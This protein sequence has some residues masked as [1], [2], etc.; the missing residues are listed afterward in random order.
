MKIMHFVYNNQLICFY[1]MLSQSLPHTTYY[2]LE[3]EQ[4]ERVVVGDKRPRA[5]RFLS[6]M[7]N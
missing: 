1:L 5:T 6:Q 7:T 3:L 2:G 4:K